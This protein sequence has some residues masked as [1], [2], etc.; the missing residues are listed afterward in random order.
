MN[1]KDIPNLTNSKDPQ[2]FI[3]TFVNIFKY[4]RAL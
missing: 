3:N 2:S 4:P 1:F